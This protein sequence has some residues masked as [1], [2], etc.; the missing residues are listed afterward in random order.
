MK[1]R[2]FSPISTSFSTKAFFLKEWQNYS[3]SDMVYSRY[4]LQKEVSL[5]T[6]EKQWTV[7]VAKNKLQ[8]F[9]QNLATWKFVFINSLR[10]PHYFS[11]RSISDCGFLNLCNKMCQLSAHLCISV[12][13]YFPG[14]QIYDLLIPHERKRQ[15]QRAWQPGLYATHV[16]NGQWHGLRIHSVTNP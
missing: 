10:T 14:D 7:L 1:R 16:Q 4:F 12:N 6:Q 5:S 3:H 13:Q 15:I 11:D 9:K 8:V 2:S